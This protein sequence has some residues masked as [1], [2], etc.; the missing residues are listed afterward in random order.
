[1]TTRFTVT[2]T[3]KNVPVVYK[4]ILPGLFKEGRGCVA[5]GRV[6]D[7]GRFL[8]RSSVG[9]ARRELYAP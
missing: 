8:C 5:Q 4:G 7:D 2:D 1:M 3:A 6:G 9:E